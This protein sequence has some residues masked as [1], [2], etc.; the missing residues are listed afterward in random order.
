MD[1]PFAPEYL[2]I[3]TGITSARALG[4]R[5]QPNGYR[6]ET[7]VQEAELCP[8]EAFRRPGYTTSPC[9]CQHCLKPCGG[10]SLQDFFASL[11]KISMVVTDT[12]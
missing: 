11:A 1:V 7:V 4:S 12:T 8:Q 2:L 9:Y 3:G 5:V 10:D 6:T